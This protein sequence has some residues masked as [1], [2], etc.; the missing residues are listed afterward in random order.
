MDT[1]QE[2]LVNS[3]GSAGGWNKFAAA[4]GSEFGWD[5]IEVADPAG[6]EAGHPLRQVLPAM[7][8]R[9]NPGLQPKTV[10]CLDQSG[11]LTLVSEAGFHCDVWQTHL[12]R[13]VDEIRVVE[14]LVVKCHRGPCDRGYVRALRRE[15]ERLRNRL[16]E[17]VP[18]AIFVVAEVDGE[19]STVVVS[20]RCQ[21]WFNLANPGHEADL[22]PM[23]DRMP[24]AKDQLRRFVR[25]AMEWRDDGDSRII[26]L[27]GEDNLVLTTAR[28][29]RYI[30]SFDVFFYPD[31]L[32]MFDIQDDDL[33]R[34]MEVSLERIDY[35]ER[36]CRAVG[37]I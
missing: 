18:P 27:V 20:E 24:R 33:V 19:S 29:L 7:N 21:K 2:Y 6:L 14:D 5:V 3:P 1:W 17:I 9:P 4:G 22:L 32:T 10:P 36:V 35:L 15:H 8:G 31:M 23:L 30:D 12:R 11:V 37:A 26:D 13:K 28:E 25:A 34:R 16:S